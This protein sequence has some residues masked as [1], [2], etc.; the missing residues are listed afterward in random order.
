MADLFVDGKKV[1]SVNN[2]ETERR[3]LHNLGAGDHT[4]EVV[5]TGRKTGNTA[6]VGIDGF[7]V[8]AAARVEDSAASLV[9][10]A[11]WLH[12]YWR[13]TDG[14]ATQYRFGY[15]LPAALAENP[16]LTGGGL[17]TGSVQWRLV[18]GQREITQY[19][20]D[21]VTDAQG[22][23]YTVD[24]EVVLADLEVVGQPLQG[25]ARAV[26]PQA[27]HYTQHTQ[28]PGARPAAGAVRAGTAGEHGGAGRRAGYGPGLRDRCGV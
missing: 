7:Q 20:L 1:A 3:T 13:V 6:T 28:P 22:N 17:T 16:R 25:Y 9:W 26:Y 10:K 21:Q 14:T 2:A 11:G 27:I 23:R 5:V 12:D 8:G 19:Y 18:D 4:L 15:H 24:Y